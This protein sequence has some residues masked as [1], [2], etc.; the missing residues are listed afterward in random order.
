MRFALALALLAVGCGGTAPPPDLKGME[1]T[2]D[3]TIAGRGLTDTDTMN[4]TLGSP[5]SVLLTFVY[6]GFSQIRA[7][8]SSTTTLSIPRQK[9]LVGMSLGALEGPVQGG[10]SITADGMVNLTLD[11]SVPGGAAADASTT[12]SY[13]LT[14][15]K[16]P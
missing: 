1:G 3:V 4:V 2:Y 8:G 6:I 15:T 16:K 5:G 9:V 14:G 7:N 12:V 11:V 13:T 10:G